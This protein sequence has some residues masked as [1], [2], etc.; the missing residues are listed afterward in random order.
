MTL[1]TSCTR[2]SIV[3]GSAHEV[4]SICDTSYWLV[5]LMKAENFILSINYYYLA[6]HAYEWF[7]LEGLATLN[8][9]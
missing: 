2:T 1:G 3:I 9:P 5:A 7:S 4:I 6:Q 8:Q